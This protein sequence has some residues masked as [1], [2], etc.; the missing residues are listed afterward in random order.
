[1]TALRSFLADNRH[2]GTHDSLDKSRS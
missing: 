2:I 1:M